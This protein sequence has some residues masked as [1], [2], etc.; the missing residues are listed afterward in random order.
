V[1]SLLKPVEGEMGGGGRGHS[2]P[3]LGATQWEEGAR[4]R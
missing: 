3:V 2:G 1:G 4:P